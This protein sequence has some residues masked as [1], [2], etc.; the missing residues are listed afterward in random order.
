VPSVRK[1]NDMS[2]HRTYRVLLNLTLQCTLLQHALLV[3][4]LLNEDLQ[5]FL[6]LASV[7]K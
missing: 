1:P 2:V 4:V 6:V 7:A 3:Q 5:V